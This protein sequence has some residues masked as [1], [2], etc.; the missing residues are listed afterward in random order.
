M[1]LSVACMTFQ[2]IDPCR[3]MRITTSRTFIGSVPRTCYQLR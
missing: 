2:R 3:L 1:R